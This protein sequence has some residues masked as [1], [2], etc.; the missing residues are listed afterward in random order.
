MFFI[1]VSSFFDTHTHTHTHLTSHKQQDT[2]N[3]TKTTSVKE[4]VKNYDVKKRER[5]KHNV[6]FVLNFIYFIGLTVH[7]YLFIYN[8]S[9]VIYKQTNASIF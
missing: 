2:T 6:Y 9:C 3:K 1:E 7:I 8:A 5:E 4:E